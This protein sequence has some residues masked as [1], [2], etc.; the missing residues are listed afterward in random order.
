M[1]R[2]RAIG[3]ARP[4][5]GAL[6]R[7][8]ASALLLDVDSPASS[9][10]SSVTVERGTATRWL[11]VAG[12][13]AVGALVLGL[14]NWPSSEPPPE[15]AA[16]EV[17]QEPDDEAEDVEPGE[18]GEEATDGTTDEDDVEAGPT[19]ELPAVEPGPGGPMLGEETGLLLV[20]GADSVQPSVVDLDTGDTWDLE[21]RGRPAASLDEALVLAANGRSPRIV[22][23]LDASDSGREFDGLEADYVELLRAQDGLIWISAQVTGPG[24]DQRI[25]AYDVDGRLQFGEESDFSWPSPTG[26]ATELREAPAGGIYRQTEGGWRF[27]TPGRLVAV[28]DEVALV[29]QCDE[30]LRC[31]RVWVD[32]SDLTA[33]LDLPAVDHGDSGFI[34]FE[35]LGS[36]RWLWTFDWGANTASLIDIATAQ[37]V[38]LDFSA[39]LLGGPS[40]ARDSP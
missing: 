9:T 2:P 34:A 3:T 7:T 25:E 31:R 40:P 35:I 26:F 6:V 32:R 1:S 24:L 39:S 19:A 16:E 15:R 13:A 14:V 37:P 27:E 23:P 28:G 36:D 11:A 29:Q 22:D 30:E 8:S 20:S 12:V 18:Q 4:V 33:E 38:P 5:A 17:A 10:S 21:A